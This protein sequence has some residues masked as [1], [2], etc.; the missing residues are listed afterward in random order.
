MTVHLKTADADF[1]ITEVYFTGYNSDNALLCPSSLIVH[2]MD[3]RP[4][5]NYQ[6][7]RSLATCVRCHGA[8]AFV[9]WFGLSKTPGKGDQLELALMCTTCSRL[10]TLHTV[11]RTL[12]RGVTKGITSWVTSRLHQKNEENIDTYTESTPLLATSMY[13]S[14]S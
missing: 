13:C 5:F 9:Y 8:R 10:R 3:G 6:V 2:T 14:I 7:S 4:Y 1:D 11:R 12:W